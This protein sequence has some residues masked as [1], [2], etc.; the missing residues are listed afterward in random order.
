MC[1]AKFVET[2]LLNKHETERNEKKGHDTTR[3]QK[4]YFFSVIIGGVAEVSGNWIE[5]DKLQGFWA[6][7]YGQQ[8][9]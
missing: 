4:F 8:Q 9:L 6:S 3:C 5:D 2:R 7:G 1:V